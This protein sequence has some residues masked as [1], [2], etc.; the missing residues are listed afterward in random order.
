LPHRKDRISSG[1]QS[2]LWIAA[3]ALGS[4]RTPHDV[5]RIAMASSWEWQER[6]GTSIARMRSPSSPV[7]SIVAVSYPNAA[8]PRPRSVNTTDWTTT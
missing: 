3:R 4:T 2:A 7:I 8:G 5:I 6:P 1:A